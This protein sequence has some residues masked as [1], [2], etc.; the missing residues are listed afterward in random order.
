MRNTVAR[1]VFIHLNSLRLKTILTKTPLAI[2]RLSHSR[3]R[4]APW[5]IQSGNVTLKHLLHLIKLML[6]N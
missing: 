6:L 2:E 5:L 1:D 4:F 3:S